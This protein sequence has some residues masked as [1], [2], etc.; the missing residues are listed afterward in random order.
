VKINLPVVG[1]SYDSCGECD[2]CCVAHGVLELGKPHYA[3]CVHANGRGCDIYVDRPPTCKDWSCEWR[4]GNLEDRPDLRPDRFGYF[5]CTANSPEVNA[6][7]TR[8]DDL[9]PPE[10]VVWLAN[11]VMNR[12]K[13]SRSVYVHGYGERP[14][15]AVY[16]G[17]GLSPDLKTYPV[18]LGTRK[19][20][21]LRDGCMWLSAA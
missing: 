18:E 20:A 1:K 14:P 8:P 17:I 21:K 5:F 11:R 13:G 6:Y 4:R 10:K 9:P 3:R 19:A 7:A 16:A 15:L 2:A 12:N